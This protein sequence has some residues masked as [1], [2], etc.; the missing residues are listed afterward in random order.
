[1]RKGWEG[2]HDRN[3]NKAKAMDKRGS[4]WIYGLIALPNSW[5]S[6]TWRCDKQEYSL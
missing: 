2:D 4:E 3:C 1:L 6:G 5:A